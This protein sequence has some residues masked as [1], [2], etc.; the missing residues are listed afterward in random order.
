[1][2]VFDIIPSDFFNYLGGNSNNRVL[3]S[4]VVVNHKEVRR[5]SVCLLLFNIHLTMH[6]AILYILLDNRFYL[7]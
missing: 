5:H 1:M 2:N 7:L 3:Q 6:Q 4:N